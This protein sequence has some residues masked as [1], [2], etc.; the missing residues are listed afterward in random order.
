[1]QK[2]DRKTLELRQQKANGYKEIDEIFY[3]QGLPF[4]TKAIQTELISRHHGNLLADHFSIKETC[5]LLAQKYYW[6]IFRY[7]V[8]AYAKSCDVCLASKTIRHKPYSDLQ[9]LLVPTH[10]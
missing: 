7:N 3:H 10:Q 1:M 6:P 9:L 2:A 5:K 8:E 4:M